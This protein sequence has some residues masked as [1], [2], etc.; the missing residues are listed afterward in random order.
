M[1][2]A[3]SDDDSADLDSLRCALLDLTRR[4]QI[5]IE[6]L[7]N[8]S[9]QEAAAVAGGVTR[10]TVSRWVG[11]HPGFPAALNLYLGS[12]V[13]DQAGRALRIR[14]K[15]Y[16]LVDEKLDGA[17]LTTALAVLRVVSAPEIPRAD[18]VEILTAELRRR[19]AM[20]ENPH[21]PRLADGTVN[22]FA[23]VD[24]TFEADWNEMT[25]RNAVEG[26]A[27]DAGVLGDVPGND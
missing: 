14:G 27:D 20:A 19:G 3:H 17:D 1:P 26:L 13:A 16:A 25:E 18:P 10:E 21:L 22:V 5:A 2:G 4:H 7:V 6:L 15:A 12:L 24:P 8:G 9:T 23:P 11:H